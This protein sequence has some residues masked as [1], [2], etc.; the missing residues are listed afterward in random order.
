MQEQAAHWKV[1]T[2]LGYE[3]LREQRVISDAGLDDVA[4]E[5]AKLHLLAGRPAWAGARISLRACRDD[6]ALFWVRGVPEPVLVDT[7]AAIL[8]LGLPDGFLPGALGADAFVSYRARFI[9]CRSI[10]RARRGRV[11]TGRGPCGQSRGT[12]W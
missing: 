11:R 6:R 8:Q 2:V 12:A 3:A 10:A 1:R 9:P 5:Q 7:S 4:V